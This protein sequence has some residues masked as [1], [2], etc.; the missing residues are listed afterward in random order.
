MAGPIDPRRIERAERA[1]T[2]AGFAIEKTETNAKGDVV[3]LKVK[4]AE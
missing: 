4:V 2:K 1:L 3:T